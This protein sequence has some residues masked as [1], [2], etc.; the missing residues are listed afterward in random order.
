MHPLSAMN[1]RALLAALL[2]AAVVACS[3]GGDAAPPASAPTTT[4]A[5]STAATTTAAATTAAAA[6]T[7]PTAAPVATAP[8]APVPPPIAAERTALD[9]APP[10]GS[11]SAGALLAPANGRGFLLVGTTQADVGGPSTA[12]MW[13]SLDGVA[14]TALDQP[15]VPDAAESGAGSAV[16]VGAALAV[17]GSITS[18]DGVRRPAV[19]WA[20]DGVTFTSTEDPFGAPGF[21]SALAASDAGLVAVGSRYVEGRREPAVAVRDPSGTWRPGALPPGTERATVAGVAAR[22][23]TVVLTGSLP[24][25]P[26]TDASAWVSVD[27]GA[28][29]V[30]ADASSFTGSIDTTLG[31]VARSPEG[32]VAVACAADPTGDVTAL[33]RS[34][35]GTSWSRADIDAVAADGERFPNVESLCTSLSIAGE[36]VLIGTFDLGAVVLDLDLQGRGRAIRGPRGAEQQS[37]ETP[38]AAEGPDGLV[39]VGREAR[40]LSAGRESDGV[41][42]AEAVGLPTGMARAIGLDLT[43]AGEQLLSRTDIYPV[44]VPEIGDTYRWET[45]PRWL[46]STDGTSWI[47][48]GPD[49]PSEASGVVAGEGVDVAWGSVNDP[50]DDELGGP[51]GGSALW[52]RTTGD[53]WRYLGLVAGGPGGEAVTD[54]ALVAAGFVAVGYASIRDPSTGQYTT[55]PLALASADGQEWGVEDP[56]S[57]GSRASLWQACPLPSGDVLGIGSATVDGS[58]LPYVVRRAAD[59]TW[60]PTDPAALPAGVLGF[61]DCVVVGDATVLVTELEGRPL[62]VRTVDGVTWSAS[63]LDERFLGSGF[64]ALA[65][66]GSMLVAAGSVDAGG[67]NDAAVWTSADGVSWTRIDATGLGGPGEQVADDVE[68]VGDGLIVSGRDRGAPVVWRLPWP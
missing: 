63:G 39:V 57:P 60:S 52:R 11:A 40:G 49:V 1:P 53:R 51:L 56:P 67:S 25:G 35:D 9:S 4:T 18:A 12:A 47:G 54:I 13:E 22:E 19:W 24:A 43:L 33:A 44:V 46:V 26:R 31:D 2:V 7:T 17:G 32:F 27:G 14:W 30:G 37:V 58:A 66:T 28:S 15:A 5:V 64:S 8:P 62:I 50:A 36:R 23:G 59:G 42:P 16:W 20:P 29:F 38:L 48:A 61:S 68:V 34:A 65:T 45:Q 3:G 55:L 6:T 41:V 10:G 21:L